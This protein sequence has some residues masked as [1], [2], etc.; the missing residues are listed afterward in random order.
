M[1][2]IH[3]RDEIAGRLTR[4]KQKL[5]EE[6]QNFPRPRGFT[7]QEIVIFSQV[8]LPKNLYDVDYAKL[9][10]TE[11]SYERMREFASFKLAW[12]NVELELVQNYYDYVFSVKVREAPGTAKD[13]R[14]AW[15]KSDGDVE[16]AAEELIKVKSFVIL[17]KDRV[18]DYEKK[19]S[20][21]Q[22]EKKRRVW[23][24]H[25]DERAASL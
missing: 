11:L 9:V 25:P 16:E 17:T 5:Q 2:N 20:L 8:E 21:L 6:R 3:A 18:Q 24:R 13:D 10:Q 14:V 1:G 4:L 15:A 7:E 19:L 12:Y 22:F 23:I